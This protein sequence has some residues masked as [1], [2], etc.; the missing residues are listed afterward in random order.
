MA[1]P[2]DALADAIRQ[3]PVVG[4]AETIW[5]VGHKLRRVWVAMPPLGS[6]SKIGTRA[7]K[8]GDSL[9]GAALAGCPMTDRHRG[10][11]GSPG[12]DGSCAPR[13]P[14]ATPKP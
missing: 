11:T 13:T 1:A 5:R 6:I 14:S 4:R 12:Y 7:A 9:L 3:Q 10:A 2:V 8:V